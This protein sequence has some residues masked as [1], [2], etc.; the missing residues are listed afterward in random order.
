MQQDSEIKGRPPRGRAPV[1]EF[2]RDD[3]GGLHLVRNTP[4][5]LDILIQDDTSTA[6]LANALRAARE[7]VRKVVPFRD[8]G[9]VNF[10]TENRGEFSDVNFQT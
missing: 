1:F 7:F 8:G 2:R 3:S 10:Q 6:E 9:G 5:R 4:P